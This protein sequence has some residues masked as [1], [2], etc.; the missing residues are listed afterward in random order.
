MTPESKAACMP[1][2]AEAF[3][4]W[5]EQHGYIWFEGDLALA[6][7]IANHLGTDLEIDGLAVAG[8]V[9]GVT[10]E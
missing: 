6:A 7:S 5:V 10:Q 2:L 9:P 4:T 1:D 3:R 8:D